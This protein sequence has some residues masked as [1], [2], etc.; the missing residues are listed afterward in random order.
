MVFKTALAILKILEPKILYQDLETVMKSIKDCPN[1][2]RFQAIYNNIKTIPNEF[3]ISP[4]IKSNLEE[5]IMNSNP[6]TE[7]SGAISYLKKLTILGIAHTKI[8]EL[9]SQIA[10]IVS[11]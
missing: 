7:I 2:K 3:F 11:L 8:T 1:L 9:P 4:N 5:F 10:R 6:L